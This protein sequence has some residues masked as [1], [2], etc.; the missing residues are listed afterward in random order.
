MRVFVVI[1]IILTS[2]GSKSG[3]ETPANADTTQVIV[4]ALKTALGQDFPELN[5]VKRWESPGDSIF[6]T[7][8]LFPLS[9]LPASVDS[10]KFRI[11]PDTLICSIIKADTAGTELPNYLRL[12]TFQKTDTGYFV[13]FESVVC[14]PSAARDASV[15]IHILKTKDK[16]EFK[17]NP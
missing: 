9:N 3:S 7:T 10:F 17:S 16:F 8:K 11:L 13:Q 12:Q 2:C 5:D 1:L 15:G 14:I 4:L 6:L